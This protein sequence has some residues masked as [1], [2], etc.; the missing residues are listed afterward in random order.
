M[1]DVVADMAAIH[2]LDQICRF[3]SKKLKI[4]SKASNEAGFL[5]NSIFNLAHRVC[6]IIF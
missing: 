4:I 6:E 2:C 3:F 5:S 1:V